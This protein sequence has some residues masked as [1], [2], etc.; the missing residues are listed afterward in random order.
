MS[1]KNKVL[2]SYSLAFLVAILT[3]LYAFTSRTSNIGV[4]GTTDS[5]CGNTLTKKGT[6]G[7]KI[8]KSLCASCHKLNKKLIGPP[9]YKAP[10]NNSYFSTYVK[11][12]QE[13]INSQNKN[14][15]IVNNEFKNLNYNH[16]FS[17]IQKTRELKFQISINTDK[18]I[19]KM[20]HLYRSALSPLF[21]QLNV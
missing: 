11:N 9:L 6:E 16:Q 2:L 19:L 5:I 21:T 20:N 13:L 17:P 7:K 10:I 18:A 15:L 3:I 12:E 8:F 14:A 1:L 4:C